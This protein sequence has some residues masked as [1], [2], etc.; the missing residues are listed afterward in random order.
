[1]SAKY[2]SEKPERKLNDE[3]IFVTRGKTVTQ[4][5]FAKSGACRNLPAQNKQN[6]GTKDYK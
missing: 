6:Y 3:S 5:A 4:E 1:M 2:V